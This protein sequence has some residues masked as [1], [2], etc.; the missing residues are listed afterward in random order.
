[1][2]VVPDIRPYQRYEEDPHYHAPQEH[3]YDQ[4]QYEQP[5]QGEGVTTREQ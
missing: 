2:V 5:A 4:L 1:V 3:Y